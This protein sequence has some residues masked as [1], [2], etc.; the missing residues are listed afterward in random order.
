MNCVNYVKKTVCM[1]LM[2][3]FVLISCL[4]AF[5][6]SENPKK[7][8][9]LASSIKITDTKVEY[10][11]Y[12]DD[13]A[14]FV[15]ETISGNIITSD[16]YKISNGEKIHSS[17]II[18]SVS[19]K[20]VI[21]RE[22][23]ANGQ[24]TTYSVKGIVS[25]DTN[26]K[27]IVPYAI[28]TDNYSISLVG[29]KVTIASAAMAITLVSNYIPTTGAEDIIKKAIV[30]VAGAVGAG[31]ACLPDYLYVTSVLSMHKSVGKIYYVYENDYYLDSNKSQLIGHWTF[32]HRSGSLKK[33][34]MKNH[35]FKSVF[36]V[37]A[38][39]LAQYIAFYMISSR[40]GKEAEI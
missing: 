20:N 8:G 7:L 5:A 4:G 39:L 37:C 29:K 22:T 21:S 1:V 24:V 16:F 3:A 6:T 38:A 14:Y 31:V 30:V 25:R 19:G 15:E 28:R 27:S 10:I 9:I 34:V 23:D 33:E 35:G 18:S 17:Q 32:R 36:E 12:K 40:L 13:G 2:L 26:E 11:E